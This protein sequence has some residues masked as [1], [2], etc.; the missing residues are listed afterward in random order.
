MHEKQ[1][2]ERQQIRKHTLIYLL[3]TYPALGLMTVL[4]LSDAVYSEILPSGFAE[5]HFSHL[6]TASI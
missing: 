5:S 2:G 6:Q 4:S 1:K 3:A